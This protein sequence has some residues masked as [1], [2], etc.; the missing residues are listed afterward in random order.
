MTIVRT[1][2]EAH[3][4]GWGIRMRCQRGDQRGIVKIDACRYETA[5]CLKTLVATR[6]RPFPLARIADRIRCPNCGDL[7]VMLAFDV[8]GSPIPVF[9]PVSFGR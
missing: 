8:P 7:G 6:G 3:D 5:L 4:A 1:L 9:R 2:G